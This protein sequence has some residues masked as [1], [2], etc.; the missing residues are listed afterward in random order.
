MPRTFQGGQSKLSA[1]RHKEAMGILAPQGLGD[2]GP[3]EIYPS[4]VPEVTPPAI[5]YSSPPTIEHIA[6]VLSTYTYRELQ[7]LAKDYE[8]LATGTR[9]ELEERLRTFSR[10]A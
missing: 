8:L 4:T 1:R 3:A 10:E 7:Q 2:F 6:D 9:V 5:S